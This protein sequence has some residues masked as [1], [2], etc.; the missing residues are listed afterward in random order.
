MQT[1]NRRA[2]TIGAFVVALLAAGGGQAQPPSPGE[3][4]PVQGAPAAPPW[5]NTALSPD[6]RAHLVQAQMTQDEE[7]ILVRGYN[8]FPSAG[9]VPGIPRLGIPE[10][11]ES[12]ASLGVAN[13]GHM[14]PGDQATALPAS[15]LTASS[16]NAM[17][18]HDAGVML[19]TEIRAKGFNVVLDGGVNLTRDPRGGRTFEYAGEEP[20]L[21]GVIAGEVV[22]GAQEQ[23][24]ISTAKHFA[25][26]DQESG[27]FTMSANIEEGPMRESDLLAF[28]IA[29]EH[30]KPGAIMC[31][32]N[33]VNGIYAC[34]NDFLLNRVLK[35]DWAYPGFVLSDWGAVHSAGLAAN[36]GLDQESAAKADSQAFFG[37]PLKQAVA[38]GEVSADRLHDMAHRILRSMFVQGLF[39]FPASP[40]PIAAEADAA[41]A[42]RVAEEGIVLLKN[43]TSLL[44]LSKP[45]RIVVIGAR[46]DIG[47]LSGGGS[48]QVVPVGDTPEQ[49]ILVPGPVSSNPKKGAKIPGDIVIYDPPS[50]LAAIRAQA[51]DADVSFDDGTDIARAT[52][53]AKESD[54]A[55][56]F[57]QQWMREGRD[58]PNLSLPGDQDAL[59]DAVAGVNPRTVVVLET[60]G[61]VLMP[62][63]SKAASVLEA[64]Y[65][66][67]GGA[68]AI[69]RILFGAAN[70]SGHLAVTFP[71]REDQ[72]PH[73][74]PPA[75]IRTSADLNYTEG[76]NVGYRWFEAQNLTPLFPFG[77]GLSYT[78]F[79]FSKL[80][81]QGGA[82]LTASYDVTNG[83]TRAGKAVAQV[84][85]EPPQGAAREVRRLIGWSKVELKP[86]ETRHLSITAD[87][88]LLAHYD[89]ATRTW[90]VAA[91]NYLV[92][93]CGSSADPASYAWTHL[94][95]RRIKP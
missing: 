48:S 27:R 85:A 3:A 56:V 33:R 88:R 46:A 95:E 11:R 58:V 36:S 14:R 76:A 67:Q 53:A 47:V 68:E 80:V 26:N 84:Y 65:P 42:G 23:H 41:I 21:A 59:I 81:V 79:R 70:P 19:G 45:K 93:L 75:A 77:Y 7:L 37:D 10:L 94:D 38:S 66:G 28:E 86:G 44:P 69:A 83:G 54:V 1:S 30:G 40:Q 18:A 74:S 91:G 50:P 87:P 72:L 22:R 43:G 31:A 64:W 60:G 13:G 5:M 55:I 92:S 71:M 57:A 32:Y 16:W 4:Q 78:T 6:Q 15:I 24:I 17:L 2:L 89:V 34:E 61:P 20:L 49:E 35:G 25:L 8:W 73:P 51:P 90:H 52:S 12:D 39:D 62:W 63:L 29:I 82:T 9:Y